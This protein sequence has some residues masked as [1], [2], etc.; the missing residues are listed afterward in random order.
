MHGKDEPLSPDW[1][2]FVRMNGE[3]DDCGGGVTAAIR[4]EI[5]RPQ[6]ETGGPP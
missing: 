6:A 4:F 1:Q 3:G 2:P 5:P